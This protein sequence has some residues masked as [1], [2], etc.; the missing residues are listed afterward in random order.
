MQQMIVNLARP[1]ARRLAS[2]SSLI[3]F[4]RK[5]ENDL[6]REE[7]VFVQEI[8]VFLRDIERV[9][10]HANTPDQGFHLELINPRA[11]GRLCWG[12]QNAPRQLGEDVCN[13]NMFPLKCIRNATQMSPWS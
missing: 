9:L 6:D 7:S 5:A 1:L 10:D 4:P 8:L 13:L 11:V 2:S 3:K 12:S